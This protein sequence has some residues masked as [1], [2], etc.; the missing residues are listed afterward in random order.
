MKLFTPKQ[1]PGA[2]LFTVVSQTPGDVIVRDMTNLLLAN[3]YWAGY[4]LPYFVEHYERMDLPTM[5]RR[6]GEE[7]SCTE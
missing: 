2:G 6:E 4:N 3:L 1:R 5:L 7:Y